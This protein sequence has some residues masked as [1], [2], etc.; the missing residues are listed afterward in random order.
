[1]RA[2]KW[3]ALV[4]FAAAGLLL[5]LAATGVARDGGPGKDQVRLEATL[6]ATPDDP[7]ALGEAR[8]ESRPDR[9]ELRIDVG[10]VS[11]TGAVDVF[12][13]GTFLG[14]IGL[15]NQGRGRL[16]LKTRDGDTVPLLA[17]GDE[18]DVVDAADNETLILSG[19]LQSR[20]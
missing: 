14:T 10:G 18:I 20:N 8:F 11:I 19:A 16:E 5:A 15:D 9:R 2:T 6:Y 17:D 3:S 12:V 7:D 1:M 13:N 4:P